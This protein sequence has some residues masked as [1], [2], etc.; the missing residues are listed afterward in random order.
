MRISFVL[1]SL[2]VVSMT[3]L[4]DP[5]DR[6]LGMWVCSDG[7]KSNSFGP[8]RPKEFVGNWWARCLAGRKDCTHS[9]TAFVGWSLD[10]PHV[11]IRGPGYCYT[12]QPYTCSPDGK[13]P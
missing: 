13:L 6:G 5:F 3:A 10:A 11:V 8:C 12:Q 4:A 1:L 2:L 9:D 7:S